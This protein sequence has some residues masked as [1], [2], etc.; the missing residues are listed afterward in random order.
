M[1]I[2]REEVEKVAGLARLDFDDEE[3]AKFV[4]QLSSILSYVEKLGELDLEGV[5]PMAHVHDIVNKPR[6]DEVRPSLSRED[7]LSNSP[8]SEDGCFK[9]SKVIEG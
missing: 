7:A 8:D 3:I 1:K 4:P 9:V 6:E 2:T 5:E